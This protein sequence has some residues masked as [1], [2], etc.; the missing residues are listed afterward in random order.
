M[1]W[2]KYFLWVPHWVPFFGIT[3]T[4]KIER[5]LGCFNEMKTKFQKHIEQGNSEIAFAQRKVLDLN[6]KI[7]KEE[8]KRKQSEKAIKRAN[9]VIGNINTF[10]GEDLED[11]D[12]A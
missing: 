8:K 5:E 11:N 1:D 12:A 3:S 10:M 4:V 7:R 6:A 9:I 2:R